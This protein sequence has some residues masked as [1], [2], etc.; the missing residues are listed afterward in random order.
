MPD[1]AGSG[2][3]SV[4]PLAEPGPLLVTVIVKPI[5]EPAFTEAASAVFV[6]A[7]FG[8]WTVMST[9]PTD[10]PVP[11]VLVADA[12]LLM[13]PQFTRFVGLEMRTWFDSPGPRSV[14]PKLSVPPLI[15]QPGSEFGPS[16]V[17]ARA[18]PVGKVS[19]TATL[20][21]IPL[22]VF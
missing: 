5:G 2:S 10:A 19:V 9:G 18:P 6:I 15:D 8:H 22:P 1:P 16:I 13:V 3:L 11:F 21:A 12:E 20:R 14:G 17:Q 4:T 7:R